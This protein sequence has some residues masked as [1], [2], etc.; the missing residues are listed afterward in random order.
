MADNFRWS[1]QHP[2][3]RFIARH[4]ETPEHRYERNLHFIARE[5]DLI[6]MRWVAS[7]GGRGLSCWAFVLHVF[8]RSRVVMVMTGWSTHSL[9]YFILG[10]ISGLP[11][12]FDGT[13]IAFNHEA[14]NIMFRL[15]MSRA[16]I[17]DVKYIVKYGIIFKSLDL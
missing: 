6:R 4:S 5:Q 7:N 2:I 17:I 8:W 3:S 1:F 13:S 12:L 10:A 15:I 14:A 9:L 16:L 11:Q